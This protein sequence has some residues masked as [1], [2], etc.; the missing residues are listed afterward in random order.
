MTAV[1]GG[2]TR[3][4]VVNV[5]GSRLSIQGPAALVRGAS[6]QYTVSLV[7]SADRGITGRALTVSSARGN[8]LSAPS[9]TT[10][11]T[12]RATVNL[13]VA[14]AGN[15][16]LTVTGLGLTSTQ[17][18]SVNSDSFTFTAPAE[19][20]EIP[21]STPQTVTIRW[22]VNGAAAVNVP[23]TFTTTRGTLTGRPQ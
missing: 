20:A 22:L 13:T 3:T 4:V 9:L 14:N 17:P 15:D 23:V 12:G 1:A 8:T 18:I 11:S 10:D 16:T 19:A 2:I 21:L 6:A 5:V 7:D